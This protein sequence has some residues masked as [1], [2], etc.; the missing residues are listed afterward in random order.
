MMMIMMKKKVEGRWQESGT[1]CFTDYSYNTCTRIRDD[2]FNRDQW[3]QELTMSR[4]KFS[5]P[6]VVLLD[7]KH[8]WSLR[9][10]HFPIHETMRCYAERDP[11]LFVSSLYL[12]IKKFSIILLF[13]KQSVCVCLSKNQPLVLPFV[14]CVGREKKR[15]YTMKKKVVLEQT[16]HEKREHKS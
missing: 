11:Y 1:S 13:T 14:S 16:C 5:L 8:F 9:I 10:N 4:F 7:Y 12:T 2:D 6:P 15:W 3:L